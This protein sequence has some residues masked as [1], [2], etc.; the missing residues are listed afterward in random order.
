[1]DLGPNAVFIWMSYGV[2]AFVLAVLIAW[3]VLDGREQQR[4]LDALAKRGV[5]R[6]SAP[7]RN[8]NAT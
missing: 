7:A 1:M 2:V 6:R 5:T 8:S 3:L 4:R